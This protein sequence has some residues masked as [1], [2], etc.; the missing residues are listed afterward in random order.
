MVKDEPQSRKDCRRD[1][2][3]PG[4]VQSTQKEAR[5]R[6]LKQEPQPWFRADNFNSSVRTPSGRSGTQDVR[7]RH[8]ERMRSYHWQ[9][10]I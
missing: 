7:S 4:R 2:N 5:G 10:L 6:S 1:Q 8:W 3:I 9:R